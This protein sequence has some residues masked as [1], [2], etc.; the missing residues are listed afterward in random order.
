MQIARHNEQPS[1]NFNFQDRIHPLASLDT[2]I[3]PFDF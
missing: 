2:D 3:W 1:R